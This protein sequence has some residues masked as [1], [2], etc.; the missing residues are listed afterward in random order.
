MA[1][2]TL[3]QQMRNFQPRFTEAEI[4]QIASDPDKFTGMVSR[5]T[6]LES[7]ILLTELKGKRA[8]QEL[9]DEL[10]Q[11]TAKS[12]RVEEILDSKEN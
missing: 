12:W 8:P 11:L 2:E 3:D 7:Q 1:K 5:I 9:H 4:E 10:D 6:R